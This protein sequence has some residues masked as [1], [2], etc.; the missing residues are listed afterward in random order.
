MGISIKFQGNKKLLQ[1][2]FASEDIF[3]FKLL[4]Q[5]FFSSF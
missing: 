5:K 3:Y 2:K 4:L 1:K